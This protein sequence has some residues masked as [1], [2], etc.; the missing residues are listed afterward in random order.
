MAIVRV[1]LPETVLESSAIRPREGT[2]YHQTVLDVKR[3]LIL[4]AID[5]SGGNYTA[6]ARLLGIN[7]T[8]LHRLVNNLQLRDTAAPHG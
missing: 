1:D 3:R 8:Y 6:A 5:R 2:A 4:D 7:P